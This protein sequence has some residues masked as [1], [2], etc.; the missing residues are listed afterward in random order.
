[1]LDQR[2]AAADPSQIQIGIANECQTEVSAMVEQV[3]TYSHKG[4]EETLLRVQYL[5][6]YNF[7][8]RF[9]WEPGQLL[10]PPPPTEEVT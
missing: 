9:Q 8:I 1:M 6:S 3:R 10:V 5:G 2:V 4:P 7:L